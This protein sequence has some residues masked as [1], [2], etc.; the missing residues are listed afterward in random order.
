MRPSQLDQQ[1][2]KT[3][4]A[5]APELAQ[6]MVEA[7]A[8]AEPSSTDRKPFVATHTAY[9]KDAT[10][11][12]TMPPPPP[13]AKRT[14]PLLIDKLGERL[15][16]ERSGVRLYD[17]LLLKLGAGQAFDRGPNETDLKHIRD[18]ELEHFEVVRDAIEVVGGDPTA[19]TPSANLVGVESMGICSV[20]TDP[21]TELA[22][23]LHAMLVAE[24]ADNAGWEQLV[25]LCK[26]AELP[27]LAERFEECRTQEAEH[28]EKVQGWL[29]AHAKAML[30]A[31][32][33]E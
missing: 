16:F 2:N 9:V 30:E 10:P 8:Q 11:V 26:S 5:Q 25:E 15:A 22:D 32:A 14:P 21:R 23:G 6:T 27:D 3:G 31:V 17:A 1:N 24:L 4:I 20:V 29:T 33:A 7:S 12:A 28:L 19:V 18:E 13:E